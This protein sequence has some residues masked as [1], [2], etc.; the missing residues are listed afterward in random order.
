MPDFFDQEKVR[1]WLL[2]LILSFDKDLENINYIFCSDDYLLE[3]NKTYLNH[4]Y[5]TD[6]ITFPYRQD[7]VVESDIFIS[8]DRV[9]ENSTELN[10]SFEDELHRV[11]VHG[12]L[13]LCGLKDKS[14]EE[15]SRMRKAEDEALK[16]L[17]Q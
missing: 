10:V 2:K 3:I 8:L 9:L 16:L 4:D 1:H 5:Y 11:I 17:N 6:I 7:D 12:V 13:H 15:A 14:D